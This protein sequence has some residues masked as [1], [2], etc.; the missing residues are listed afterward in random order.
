MFYPTWW[1]Q[2][3]HETPDISAFPSWAIAPLSRLIP[4]PKASHP[5]LSALSSDHLISDHLISD[6]LNSDHQ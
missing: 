2:Q 6:H 1:L 5:Q 3:F 4:T